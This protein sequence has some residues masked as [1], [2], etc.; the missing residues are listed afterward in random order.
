M[1][2]VVVSNTNSP[3]LMS[4]F[5]PVNLFQFSD[6]QITIKGS[7]QSPSIFCL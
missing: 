3:G 6:V 5:L 1:E 4:T 7:S 2:S